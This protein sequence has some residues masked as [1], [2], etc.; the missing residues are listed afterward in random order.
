METKV[1]NA[2]IQSFKHT[3]TDEQRFELG[4]PLELA[5]AFYLYRLLLGRHPGRDKLARL[6]TDAPLTTAREFLFHLLAS[7]EFRSAKPNLPAGF[8]ME[9]DENGF[10]FRFRTDD[11]EMGVRMGLGIYEPDVVAVFR[12]SE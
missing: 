11:P 8:E 7:P 12:K 6:E 4:K 3:I 10:I 2:L 1:E 5:D 9:S